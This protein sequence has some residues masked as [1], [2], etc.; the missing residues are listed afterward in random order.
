MNVSQFSVRRPILSIMVTL[1]VI[2]IGG[3]SLSRLS[4]DL[5]PDI[6]YP[7]LSISTVYENASPEEVEELITRPVEEAM[8]A[9]PGVEEVTSISA[10]GRSN[11]RVTFTWGTDLDAAA[12]DIRD[13]LDR[14]VPRLP[15]D[16]ER[17]VLRKFD[18]ASFPILILGVSSNLDPIQVRRIIDNQV[19]NRIERVPGVAFLDIHGGLD[20]EIHVNLNAEKMK[21]LGLPVDQL[22]TRLEDENIN[23]PAGTIEQGHLDVTIRTPGVYNDLKELENTVV[24]MREGVPIQI[25]DIATVEDSW[26]KVTR[27]IRINGKPGVRLAVNKQ[28]GKNTVE[29]ATGVLKEIE[30]LNQDIPQLHILPII[31]T[32]DY[33]KRS[34][35]NVG[36]TILYGGALAVFVLLFFLRNIPSTAVI[37]TSI[38]VSIVATFSLMYFGG[39]TLNLMTLGGLALGVGMLVDNAIVVLENIYRLREAGQDPE[40][41]AIG[42]SQEVFAAV[43]A[44]TLTTLVVFLPLI[45]VRGMSGIMFKQLSYVVSFSLACSLVVALTLVP[46]MASWVRRPLAVEKN[47]NIGGGGKIYRI[48]GRLFTWMEDEYKALL[49][50]S[51]SHKVLILGSALLF[52]VGS[53]LLIPLVGVELMPATDESE[54]RVNAEMAVGTRLQLVDE[55]F[56]KIEEIVAQEVPEIDNT[57]AFIGGSTFR[58]QGGNSGEM[59]VA[60]KPVKER[61]RS[62]EEI[63]V[64]LRRRLMHIPGVTIRTRAGQGLFLLKIGTSGND[65]VQVEVRGYD[66]EASEALARR[67]REIVDKVD[68]ITDSKISRESGTPEEL[69]LID[70]QK[71]ANMKLTVSKIAEMLQTVLSGTAA[72]YYRDAGTEYMI[73]VK[74]EGAE[75]KNLS[76]ILDLPITNADGDPVILRNVVEIRP[77]RGPVLIERKAQERVVYVTANF[78]GRDMGSVLAD[79]RE[80]LKTVPV[81]RDFSILFGGDY[82]EQQKAFRELMTSFILSLLLV[83]MVMACLY[84]SLRYPLVVMFSV[85]LAA[86]GVILMLFLSGTTFNIQSF[87]GC[88]MLG[89]IV[90]NNAILLVDHINLLRQRDGF[91]LR[92]AIEEAGRRRLRPILMTASTTT[93]AMAPLALGIGEGGEA[94]APMARTIIGGLTS[95]SLITLLVTPTIYA[96]FERKHLKAAVDTTAESKLTGSEKNLLREPA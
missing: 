43:I 94:Q 73:R 19:K 9:V 70:R 25:R 47:V 83:Y 3:I 91:P 14:V 44:S 50:F 11:V 8:S 30:Q 15:D 58:A 66:L 96:V 27:I 95:S 82:E 2:I 40:G 54:V 28:S 61:T 67:V 71:A 46:M 89:G 85:P 74:L 88:I 23:L 51:L 6:T 86:I 29:V 92:E 42:G 38:P 55:V 39:F 62:S 63:A 59:R 52:L 79:V 90:V 48:T 56:K 84:E 57:V 77:R 35:T 49:R 33:I 31:N 93:L 1:I 16:A 32:S 36:T 53:L 21:A 37:A 12:N 34:I 7:T 41:A 17:P 60:L 22:L 78:T 10:E 4:I 24:A 80:G 65:N 20:R 76:D 69:I 5:M 75:K 81:P 18:L 87:I 72:G 68:G 26:E 13:R 64:A 45:F